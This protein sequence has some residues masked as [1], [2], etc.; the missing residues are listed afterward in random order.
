MT[1]VANG[2]VPVKIENKDGK[3]GGKKYKKKKK[4]RKQKASAAQPIIPVKEEEEDKI[5]IEYVTANP[6]DEIDPNDPSYQE[7]AEI[8]Q[9]FTPADT[10]E[11][12]MEEEEEA[13]KQEQEEEVTLSNRQKKKQKRL[14]VAVLKTLVKRP[15]VVEAWDVNARDPGLLVYLK[16]YRNTVPV[17]SHWSQKRRYLQGKRG[18]EKVPFQLPEFI[19]ATGISKIRA[20]IH[21]K[22]TTNDRMKPKLGKL[23]IDYQVCLVYDRTRRSFT[24]LSSDIKRNRN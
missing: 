1:E 24:T 22:N 15:D 23:D 13:E 9:R 2:G 18:I 20:N 4:T 6:L 21:S 10:E 3:K 7:F 19:A 12:M 16:S 8:F 17:P 11:D 14:S 5:E